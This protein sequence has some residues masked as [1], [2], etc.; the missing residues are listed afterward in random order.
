MIYAYEQVSP[1]QQNKSSNDDP[2]Y[3]ESCALT[4][5]PKTQVVQYMDGHSC[6]SGEGIE[7]KYRQNSNQV[8]ICDLD[9]NN[10]FLRYQPTVFPADDGDMSTSEKIDKPHLQQQHNT[11]AMDLWGHIRDYHVRYMHRNSC[12]S[13]GIEKKH[14]N[15]NDRVRICDL[16][17]NDP[18]LRYQPTVFPADDGYMSTAATTIVQRRGYPL[19]PCLKQRQKVV[20]WSKD[21]KGGQEEEDDGSVKKTVQINST[22]NQ[23]HKAIRWSK[24]IKGRQE[25]EKD[26]VEQILLTI[27]AKKRSYKEVQ[28]NVAKKRRFL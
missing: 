6:Q 23:S 3:K 2:I 15:N 26:S 24:D 11:T 12:Q 21:V 4:T 10:P 27:A 8:L 13:G 25:V 5:N 18:F 20:R 16:S 22:I 19:K 7:K 14:G 17:K 9:K 1:T 28:R